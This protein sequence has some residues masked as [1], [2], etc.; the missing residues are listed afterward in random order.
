MAILIDVKF[1]F[2][3]FFKSRKFDVA[4]KKILL[5]FRRKVERIR[6]IRENLV[7]RNIALPKSQKCPVIGW[8]EFHSYFIIVV[9]R[10]LPLRDGAWRF[11]DENS[12]G[13]GN[14]KAVFIN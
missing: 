5:F 10:L 9:F 1:C 12:S 14:Y 3:H 11:L 2:C 4:Q 6:K 13:Q 8:L 7:S